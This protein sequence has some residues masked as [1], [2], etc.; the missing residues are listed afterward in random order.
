VSLPQS[1]WPALMARAQDGDQVAYADVLGAMIPA[2]RAIVRRQVRDEALVD[3]VVQDVLLAIH[4]VR[5]TYDP[6]RPILPWIGA[7]ASARTVDMLRRSGRHRHREAGDDE[8]LLA[9]ADPEAVGRIEGFAAGRELDGLLALLPARQRQ[10]V[11][12]VGLQEL[13]LAEAAR[14]S[15]LSVSAIKALLHRAFTSLRHHKR[16]D[17]A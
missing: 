4:R 14:A 13:S 17:H 6:G 9:F 5:H 10:A 11:E 7:I 12:L 3:D 2:I 8:A 1:G 15:S 16:E